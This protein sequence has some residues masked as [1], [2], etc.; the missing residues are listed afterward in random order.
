[1]RTER[2]FRSRPP[3]VG[4]RALHAC[5]KNRVRYRQTFG[6]KNE[7]NGNHGGEC[8]SSDERWSTCTHNLFH[9]RAYFHN[10]NCLFFIFLT[11][12]EDRRTRTHS[13]SL[14]FSLS[15]FNTRR[16]EIEMETGR[17][18]LV[19]F[20]TKLLDFRYEHIVVGGLVYAFL[21]CI[22]LV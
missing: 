17:I 16:Y 22:S 2:G 21:F 7:R 19:Y 1:M 13:L 3:G 12:G 9:L 11:A 4:R 5:D 20:H 10:F 15:P 8:L 6:P 14:P 18:Y